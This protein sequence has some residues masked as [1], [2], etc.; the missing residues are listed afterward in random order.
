MVFYTIDPGEY[1]DSDVDDADAEAIGER[2][3][4][5]PWERLESAPDDLM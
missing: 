3:S 5:L 2:V 4:A 1:V